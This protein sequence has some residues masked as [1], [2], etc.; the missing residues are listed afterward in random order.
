M[1]V[2]DPATLNDRCKMALSQRIELFGHENVDGEIWN[3]DDISRRKTPKIILED[4]PEE[5]NPRLGRQVLL[6][7]QRVVPLKLQG[8]AQQQQLL[9][10]AVLARPPITLAYP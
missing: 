3:F 2:L 6:Y 9:T 4:D 10:I 7:Q 8:Q 1:T 5:M